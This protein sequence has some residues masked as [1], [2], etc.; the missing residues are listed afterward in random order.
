MDEALQKAIR[1]LGSQSALAA[2]LDPPLRPQAVQQ[3][4]KVPPERV[5]GVARATQFVVTPHELRPDLYPN[6]TDGLPAEHRKSVAAREESQP[7]DD[8]L[9]ELGTVLRDDE[10]TALK[11]AFER[12]PQYA[13]PAIEALEVDV[14]VRAQ[15]LAAAQAHQEA[16]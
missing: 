1:R 9:G 6:P 10:R 5:I 3:W 11:L 2:S 16:A 4:D 15:L 8:L 12:G 7:L 14:S 13:I